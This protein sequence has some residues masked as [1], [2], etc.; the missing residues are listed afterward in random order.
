MEL[1]GRILYFAFIILIIMI[2]VM[3]YFVK[4]MNEKKYL[5]NK[6]FGWRSSSPVVTSETR[7]T[8]D[9]LD[10][11][12]ISCS[13]VSRR[14]VMRT[15]DLYVGVKQNLCVTDR[16]TERWTKTPSYGVAS[17]RSKRHKSPDTRHKYLPRH[18]RWRC[19]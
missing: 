6:G 2:Q 12:P 10:S 8:T 15:V 11:G 4:T 18:Y 19:N 17:S 13:I 7:K 9:C 16:L 14:R 3:A 5:R 1:K